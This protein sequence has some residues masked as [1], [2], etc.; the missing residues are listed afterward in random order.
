MANNDHEKDKLNNSGYDNA[1][2][3]H[4]TQ[5][6]PAEKFVLH[7]RDKVVE[8]NLKERVVHSVARCLGS[9]KK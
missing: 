9:T 1:S 5:G 7:G 2:I 6:V 4:S 3:T 8:E